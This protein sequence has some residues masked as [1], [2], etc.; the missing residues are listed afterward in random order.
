MIKMWVQRQGQQQQQARM[1]RRTSIVDTGVK[2]ALLPLPHLLL[3]HGIN[4][5]PLLLLLLLTAIA[6]TCCAAQQL[7]QLIQRAKAASLTIS[8]IQQIK[9]FLVTAACCN[10]RKADAIWRMCWCWT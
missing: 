4:V 5:L 9:L 8:C 1:I 3:K 2:S 10:D 7:L 6:S